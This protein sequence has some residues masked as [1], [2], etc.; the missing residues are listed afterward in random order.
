MFFSAWGTIE[1]FTTTGGGRPT[2]EQT[3][4]AQ[5][6]TAQVTN[7]T[8]PQ[9]TDM[10]KRTK[11]LNSLATRPFTSNKLFNIEFPFNPPNNDSI[12]F[13]DNGNG[14]IVK[15][16]S[17]SQNV[18]LPIEW[19]KFINLANSYYILTGD[20]LVLEISLNM[21]LYSDIINLIRKIVDN[22]YNNMNI[23]IT[24]LKNNSWLENSTISDENQ[25][26]VRKQF[27][28]LCNLNKR[29]FD[30]LI[31]FMDSTV[32]ILQKCVDSFNT[33][34]NNNIRDLVRKLN[35][36]I[37][38][39][40]NIGNIDNL[41]SIALLNYIM[42]DN[43]LKTRITS[44][45]DSIKNLHIKILDRYNNMTLRTMVI[46]LKEIQTDLSLDNIQKM[47]T[48]TIN[49]LEQQFNLQRNRVQA[50]V[51]KDQQLQLQ[52]Q[53]LKQHEQQGQQ[54]QVQQLQ[55]QIQQKLQQ[56]Q[57]KVQQQ[58]INEQVQQDQKL[59]QKIIN[60]EQKKQ[61]LQQ[62][63]NAQIPI[64]K[65]QQAI[66]QLRTEIQQLETEIQPR[67]QQI[68]QLL[69][70]KKKANNSTVNLP[71]IVFFSSRLN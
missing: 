67:L 30:D 10:I 65:R 57:E 55:T 14:Y 60:I 39:N 59:S 1:N 6:T 8:L 15:F 13:S 47:E 33:S 45:L 54:Q 63:E 56:I 20:K 32:A 5:P 4:Q 52:M 41:V 27:F 50:E 36:N 71:N 70:E 37:E 62:L 43:N 23:I 21:T 24:L 53:Q 18:C 44:L 2:A 58:L 46:I 26:E 19:N 42:I 61:V 9:I 11:T 28:D 64:H 51:R 31:T 38:S 25:K 7:L 34:N 40:P 3:D 16:N 17:N 66:E 48:E 35:P 29:V 69:E 22:L 49:A 12:T 68:K